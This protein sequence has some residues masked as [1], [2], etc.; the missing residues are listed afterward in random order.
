[1]EFP[2]NAAMYA[3][4]VLLNPEVRKLFNSLKDKLRKKKSEEN[5]DDE[6]KEKTNMIESYLNYLR[7]GGEWIQK[8]IKSPGTLHKALHVPEDETIPAKKLAVKP[9][10]S[11]KMK[12]RKVL[13]QTLRKINKKKKLGESLTENEEMILSVISSKI[14]S[15]TN[16]SK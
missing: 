5:P 13:A 11:S 10:D 7:E 15:I 12:K 16:K 4:D 9:G 8:A 3:D 2:K 1:M 14:K 6:N